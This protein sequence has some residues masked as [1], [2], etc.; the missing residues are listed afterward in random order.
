MPFTPFHFGPHGCIS[1]P[2]HRRLDIPVFIG[3]NVAID[4]EPLVVMTYDLDYPVHGYC[5]TLLVGGVVGVLFAT[6]AYPVRRAI[7]TVMRLFRLPYAPSWGQMAL[8]GVLGAWLHVLFDAPLYG[9]IRPF[10]P[11]QA[12]PLYGVLSRRGLQHL[13]SLLCAGAAAVCGLHRE[14]KAAAEQ[15]TRLVPG[16]LLVLELD[17]GGEVFGA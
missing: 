9:D 15:L 13:C 12:N 4:I 3:V 7:G 16:R 2:L 1:L 11:M 5:H 10:Y 8:S 17:Q 6:A 14:K